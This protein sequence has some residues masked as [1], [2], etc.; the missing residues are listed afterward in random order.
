MEKKINTFF[1]DIIDK[2]L[3]EIS[4]ILLLIISVLIRIH[5][6]PVCVLSAD[7]NDYIVPWV[8]QYRELGFYGG[9]SQTIGNYYV[10]YNV[11]LAVISLF[12]WEPYVL[13]ALTSCIAEYICAYF[14]ARIVEAV[15]KEQGRKNAQR[16]ALLIGVG[17]LYLPTV[18][19]NGSLWKQCDAIYVCIAIISIY[20]LIER[21][22]T[23]AFVLFSFAFCFKMQA[24]FLLPLFIVLYMKEKNFSIFQ[25]LWIPVMYAITGLPA[26]VCGRGIKATYRV[27]FRQMNGYD[28]MTINAPNIY[29]FG[30]YDYPALSK[31]AIY[32]T[33]AILI[34]AAL[35]I[36]K[37]EIHLNSGKI[38]YMAGWVI[39]TCYMFLPAMH[40]RYDYAVILLISV[41]VL[42]EDTTMLWVAVVINLCAVITYSNSLFGGTGIP[43][44]AVALPYCGAYF[45][46][47]WRI[48]NYMAD[49]VSP[50]EILRTGL[51]S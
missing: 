23:L 47:T 51:K 43:M 5:L 19:L 39:W 24:I 18:I 45:A 12:P 42:I 20:L 48:K 21:K 38:L 30:L 34:V 44:I 33:V 13:V 14:V 16:K 2:Y 31:V 28:G 17:T 11:L 50:S 7:Y 26:I 4:I 37:K 29:Q 40:E 46:L 41:I 15:L 36:C 35:Y 8:K 6:A 1:Y 25:F 3:F 49:A 22:Y 27:Y 32:A 10:P 9:L